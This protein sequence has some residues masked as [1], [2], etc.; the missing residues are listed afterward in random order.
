MKQ[1]KNIK[2][3]FSDKKKK[4]FFINYLKSCIKNTD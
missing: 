2:K 1:I 3:Y 4:V